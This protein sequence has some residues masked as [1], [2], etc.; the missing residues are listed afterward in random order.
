MKRRVLRYPIRPDG[1]VGPQE[2]YGPDVLG[3]MGF[4]DGIAFDEAGNLWVTF[5]MWNAIGYI[6]PQRELVVVLE[7]P[8]RQV[9]KRP[10]H[11]LRRKGKENGLYRQ[12]RRA[13]HPLLRG[14]YPGARLVH[15]A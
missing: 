8:E 10:A 1:S 14:P 3:K 12:P 6:T 13:K 2:V 15:Q 7:D 11:L 9:L 5:P 4:P